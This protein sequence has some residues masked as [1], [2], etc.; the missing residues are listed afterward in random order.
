MQEK[1]FTPD[2]ALN[3]MVQ[4]LELAIRNGGFTR[5]QVVEI[6]EAI[7]TFEQPQASTMD[8]PTDPPHDP[9]QPKPPK[10]E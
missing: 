8:A 4:Y 7:S 5:K 2:Q 1:R 3:V 10:P 6:D 9:S